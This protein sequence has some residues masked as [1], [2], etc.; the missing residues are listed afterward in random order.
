MNL[1]P[2]EGRQRLPYGPRQCLPRGR[3]AK[4]DDS[5]H[6][7]MLLPK[8]SRK[9][10]L[11]DCEVEGFSIHNR[12][13]VIPKAKVPSASGTDVLRSP[14]R[15]KQEAPRERVPASATSNQAADVQAT[16]SADSGTRGAST[17]AGKASARPKGDRE[18]RTA[19]A[20]SAA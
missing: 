13:I 20:S 8:A 10:C 5:F 1:P 11:A 14:R 6:A 7:D 9:D 12:S 16:H 4:P 18:K 19:D 3:R 2:Q 17:P 15:D